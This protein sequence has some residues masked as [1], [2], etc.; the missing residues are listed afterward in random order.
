MSVV[1]DVNIEI[2]GQV[3]DDYSDNKYYEILLAKLK[4]VCAE[5][6]LELIENNQSS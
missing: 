1:K 4:I 6:D 2:R 5:Y 3:P